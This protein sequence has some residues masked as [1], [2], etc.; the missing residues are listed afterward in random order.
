MVHLRVRDGTMLSCE[1][2]TATGK[3]L[4]FQQEQVIETL[5]SLGMLEWHHAPTLAYQ[6]ERTQGQGSLSWQSSA[7]LRPIA[8]PTSVPYRLR[9]EI[10]W[11]DPLPRRVFLLIDGTRNVHHIAKLLG[12]APEEILIIIQVL[13]EQNL[14]AF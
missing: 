3:P 6:V 12:K 2:K 13:Q 10:P 4:L 5:K 14:I 9:A 8:E 7:P 11:L 1:I